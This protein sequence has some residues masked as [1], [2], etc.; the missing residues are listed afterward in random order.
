MPASAKTSQRVTLTLPSDREILMTRV[1]DAPARLVFEAWT[2]PEHLTHWFG[3]HG[4]TLPVCELDFQVGGGLR[5]VMRGPQG[6]EMVS[7]GVYREIVPYDRLVYTESYDG[8]AG[9]SVNTLTFLEKDGK[10]TLT[11]RMVYQSKKNR[12]AMM[13]TSMEEGV[14]ECYD[15]LAGHLGTMDATAPQELRISRVFDAPREV[16]FRAWTDAGQLRQWWGPKGF[17]NPVCEVDARPGG[18]LRIH[19][20]APDGVIYPMTAVFLDV[21]PPERIVFRN[22]ALNEKGESMFEVLQTVIFAEEG[23]KTRVTVH[24]TVLRAGAEAAPH[25]AGMEMGWSMTLDRLGEHLAA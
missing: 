13:G 8:Y 1:F 20:R 7:R 10:T 22:A 15:R 12:D 17:T 6:E 2:Q 9:E 24:A 25:L 18:A 14:S 3:R 5:F 16:V 11:T 21:A 4:W 23:S 19:M